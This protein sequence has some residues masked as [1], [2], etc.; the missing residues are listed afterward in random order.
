MS[1]QNKPPPKILKSEANFIFQSLG[2]M[3]LGVFKF[4]VVAYKAIPHHCL[5]IFYELEENLKDFFRVLPLEIYQERRDSPTPPPF[6]I[7]K[8]RS[9]STVSL[10]FSLVWES[11]TPEGVVHT[12]F[13]LV[14]KYSL[15]QAYKQNKHIFAS[16]LI[17]SLRT[18]SQ[19]WKSYTLCP[20][21]SHFSWKQK[22]ADI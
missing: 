6:S 11:P 4:M 3:I 14:L 21:L 9:P 1:P 22:L 17:H 20:F 7:F 16:V 12:T 5:R 2:S 10:R 15:F 19:P 8:V 13:Q 18:H